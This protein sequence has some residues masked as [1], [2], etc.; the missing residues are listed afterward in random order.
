[1]L[2]VERIVIVHEGG[3]PW[4]VPLVVGLGIAVV[5]AAASYAAT[6]R[7]KK[8]DV[9][10]E[11]AFRAADLIDEAEQ[12]AARKERFEAE[13]ASGVWLR[14]QEARVRAQPLGSQE[15][16]ERFQAFLDYALMFGVWHPAP[17]PAVAIRW[18]QD[19]VR[20]IRDGLV[21]YLAAPRFLPRRN[22][23]LA[24]SFPTLAEIQAMPHGANGMDLINA[25]G[26]WNAAREAQPEQ[27]EQPEPG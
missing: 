12:I 22:R 4:W 20:N 19:A 1:M 26:D 5:A 24:R 2:A 23:N 18:L 21:P 11:N 6:W 9:D 15:L 17:P 27:P 25:L 3:T 10:R 16:D 7:F 13:G 8:R 14:V